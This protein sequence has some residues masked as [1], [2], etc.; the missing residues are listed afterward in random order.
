MTPKSMGCLWTCAETDL[1]SA[2]LYLSFIVFIFSSL[3]LPSGRIPWLGIPIL[4]WFSA[5]PILLFSPS[6]E[7]FHFISV[8][9][10]ISKI[11]G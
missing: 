1:S 11:S 5:A 4:V 2:I 3:V 6:L 10:C 8:A 7:R 9:V